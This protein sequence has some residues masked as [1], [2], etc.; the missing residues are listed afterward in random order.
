MVSDAP[1]LAEQCANEDFEL[2]DKMCGIRAVLVD[3]IE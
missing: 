1:A 3:G 2:A